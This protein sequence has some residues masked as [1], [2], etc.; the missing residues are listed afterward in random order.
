MKNTCTTNPW[1]WRPRA[2]KTQRFVAGSYPK[3][4]FLTL[5]WYKK[6]CLSKIIPLA[7]LRAHKPLV[8]A[9]IT[10]NNPVFSSLKLNIISDL[11][12]KDQPDRIQMVQYGNMR[13]TCY[14]LRVSKAHFFNNQLHGG[15]SARFISFTLW[16]V[17]GSRNPKYIDRPTATKTWHHIVLK[18]TPTLL[19][20]Y[21]SPKR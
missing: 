19:F 8:V 7:P 18:E 9:M 12:H 4:N 20:C 16:N 11:K 17:R 14:T 15:G 1:K 13:V 3:T 21:G 2:P 10:I 6:H 5:T